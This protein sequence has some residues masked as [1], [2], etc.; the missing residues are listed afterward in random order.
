M[1]N[2]G[3]LGRRLRRALR[4]QFASQLFER[5][6]PVILLEDATL[7]ENV[8]S[9]P[10]TRLCW[11]RGAQAAGGAGLFS[12]VALSNPAGSGVL[13][14]LELAVVSEPDISTAT[15]DL[16]AEPQTG[17]VF[18]T[19]Q[20]EGFRDLRLPNT[21]AARV[22][23]RAAVAVP[24]AVDLRQTLSP[25]EFRMMSIIDENQRVVWIP[26]MANVAL[27]V[28]MQWREIDKEREG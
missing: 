8:E 2:A 26:D 1:A 24:S 6:T 14:V 12:Q 3:T 4:D 20:D 17:G 23:S 11:G 19:A 27:R 28:G 15:T 22:S 7:P 10:A 21:C 5:V 13:I 16:Y 9:S 25:G 18:G